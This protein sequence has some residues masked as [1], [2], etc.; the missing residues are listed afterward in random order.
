MIVNLRKGYPNLTMKEEASKT[1]MELFAIAASLTERSLSYLS[2]SIVESYAKSQLPAQEKTD[3]LFN[4]AHFLKDYLESSGRTMEF[5]ITRTH[6]ICFELNNE[7]A[8]KERIIVLLHLL[9]IMVIDN[10]YSKEEESLIEAVTEEFKIPI[11][12]VQELIRLIF[13]KPGE[14]TPLP[15]FVFVEGSNVEKNDE[16]EGSWIEKHKPRENENVQII[17][18]PGFKNSLCFFYLAGI[19]AFAFRLSASDDIQFNGREVQPGRYLLMDTED[20]LSGSIISTIPFSILLDALQPSDSRGKISLACRKLSYSYTKKELQIKPFSVFAE[21]GKMICIIGEKNAGKSTLIQILSGDFKDYLGSITLNGYELK[22]EWFK[23]RNIIGHVPKKDIIINELSV[24]DNFYYNAKLCFS[25]LPE[26]EIRDKLERLLD[27]LDLQDLRDGIVH[28]LRLTAFVRKKINIGLELLKDPQLLLLDEPLASLSSSEAESIARLLK[29][30]AMSGKLV[31]ASV[32]HTSPRAFRLFNDAWVL[33]DEGYII[34]TGTA[35]EALN[36]FNTENPSSVVIENECE[37]CGM[38]DPEKIFENIRSRKIDEKGH[39]ITERKKTAIEWHNIYKEKIEKK[40]RFK[41]TRKVLPQ[42]LFL[43]P[44][45]G[46]QNYIYSIRYLKMW[47][48]NL[49]K[50]ALNL[51]LPP[52]IALLL[53]CITRYDHGSVYLFSQNVNIPLYFFLSSIAMFAIGLISSAGEFIKYRDRILH[54]EVITLTRMGS[55]NVRVFFLLALTGVQSLLFVAVGDLILQIKE[56]TII[57]WLVLFSVSGFGVLLGLLLS[58][59]FHSRLTVYALIPLLLIPEILFGGMAIDFNHLPNPIRNERFVPMTAEFMVTRWGFEALMVNQFKNN[60]YESNYYNIDRNL[61]QNQI[62]ADIIIPSLQ[63][64]I[65]DGIEQMHKKNNTDSIQLQLLLIKNEMQKIKF[66]QLKS[67]S[68]IFPFEYLADL[69]PKRFTQNIAE[70]AMNYLTFVRNQFYERINQLQVQRDSVDG[71]LIRHYGKAGIEKMKKDFLNESVSSK[72]KK[73]D[74]EVAIKETTERFIPQK[75][76]VYVFPD[77]GSGRAHLFAPF[78][79]LNGQYINT[80]W[81]NLLAIW[82]LSFVLYIILI[83]DLAGKAYARVSRWIKK[84]ELSVFAG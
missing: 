42:V 8:S 84:S 76:P 59:T 9:D 52:L 40:L 12:D 82:I 75:F 60:P 46:Y 83:S 16:L 28:Q 79:L 6:E 30:L 56:M 33:D 5:I 20:R 4:Y 48:N 2:R 26:N 78:K 57:S 64:K 41:E 7:L 51:L 71:A 10:K 38:Y 74:S 31:I 50:L 69:D 19:H 29:N 15:N 3:Y 62:Y 61:T 49:P 72:V 53:A 24:Y 22:L 36:Y 11:G 13:L 43:N 68:D 67:S 25:S 21:A 32:N 37:N 44:N 39:F 1:L 70:E 58:A 45:L 18:R 80:E 66:D 14:S 73:L 47:T 65:L 34:Y 23:L 77:A 17:M 63:A 27:Q 55:I 81:F 35:S 54:E